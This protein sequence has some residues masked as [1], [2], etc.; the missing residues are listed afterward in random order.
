M[1]MQEA[2]KIGIRN[3]FLQPGTADKDVDVFIDE[4]NANGDCNVIKDCVLLQSLE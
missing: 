3:F 2:H 1:Y 4:I